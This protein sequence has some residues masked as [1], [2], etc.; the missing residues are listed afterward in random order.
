[1]IHS[2]LHAFIDYVWGIALVLSPWVF[3]FARN[4][5]ETWLPVVLGSLVIFYSFFTAYEGGLVRVLPRQAHL[6]IDAA[7]GAL[8][9]ISP[10]AFG[11]A[12]LIWL[13]HLLFGVALIVG[14]LSTER[15]AVGG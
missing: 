4:G 7:I 12:G 3:G 5:L 8:L 10:W 13:P 15:P 6:I 11:F 1:M 14:A 9:L 2:K